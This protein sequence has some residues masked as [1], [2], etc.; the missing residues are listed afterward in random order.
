MAKKYEELDFTDDF[1]FCKVLTNN[2]ELC[3]ELLELIIGRKVGEFLQIEK[4]KQ[5]EI[6]ADGKADDVSE[7]MKEFLQWMV[8]GHLGNSN[9]VKSL[10]DAVQKARD[11][12][13]WRLEYMTLLMRDNQM[14]EEGRKEGREEGR[15][16]GQKKDG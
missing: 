3:R 1:M 15:M 10:D 2:P 13:K 9:L 11:H 6:T 8:T 5:I 7:E 12:E 4:Q 14:R 16:E